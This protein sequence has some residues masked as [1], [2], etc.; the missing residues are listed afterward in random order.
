MLDPENVLTSLLLMLHLG[1][2]TLKE[3]PLNKTSKSEEIVRLFFTLFTKYSQNILLY[4]DLEN[5]ITYLL[6]RLHL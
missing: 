2:S 1:D 4:D 3:S 5:I 6:L